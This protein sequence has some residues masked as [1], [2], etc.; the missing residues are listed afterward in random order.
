[1]VLTK[2][3]RETLDELRDEQRANPFV[4]EGRVVLSRD[5]GSRRITGL[6]VSFS[7]ARRTDTVLAAS[8]P[9]SQDRILAGHLTDAR[10]KAIAIPDKLG[11]DRKLKE[12]LVYAAEHHDT[13]KDRDAWQASIY[14]R[15]PRK[16]EDRM[17]WQCLAKTK[18][19]RVDHS[20]CP[21]YRH[22]LGSL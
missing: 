4:E 7:R 8:A 10:E 14:N 11:L 15:K 9:A 19:G 5:E 13:G 6:L 20:A 12:C 16:P 1:V 18:H 2:I 21:G 17:G 3:V 22:E